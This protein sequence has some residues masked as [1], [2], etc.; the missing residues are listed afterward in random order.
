MVSLG[1][2]SHYY[3]VYTAH[4][5]V[6]NL[7]SC[8]CAQKRRIC[9]ENN[10]YMPNENFVAILAFAEG[11]PTSATLSWNMGSIYDWPTLLVRILRPMNID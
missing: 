3:M 8:N 9:R 2:E 7:Q 10:K 5:T 1:Y 11:L 4:Y 6:L